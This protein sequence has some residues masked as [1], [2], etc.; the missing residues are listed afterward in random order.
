LHRFQDRGSPGAQSA[1]SA[2]EA[3]LMNMFQQDFLSL[4]GTFQ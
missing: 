2:I 1:L 3:Q 4:I